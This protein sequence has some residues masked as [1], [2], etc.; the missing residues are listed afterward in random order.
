VIRGCM[1]VLL[2]SIRALT[3]RK[4]RTWEA[5]AMATL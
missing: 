4:A 2:G 1:G 5:V 3:R